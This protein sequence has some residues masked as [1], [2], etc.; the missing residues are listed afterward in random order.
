MQS[1]HP[2]ATTVL[3]DINF[4][5]V[6]EG[7]LAFAA[8]TFHN[9]LFSPMGSSTLSSSS[10]S[11]LGSSF[12]TYPTSRFECAFKLDL[13]RPH[14]LQTFR[15]DDPTGQHVGQIVLLHPAHLRLQVEQP[16]LQ[17]QILADQLLCLLFHIDLTLLAVLAAALRG[18]VVEVPGAAVAP[19]GPLLLSQVV[20]VRVLG[21]LTG[22]LG[23]PW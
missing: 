7:W 6:T 1:R 9:I 19:L 14:L 18:D 21:F 17:L 20:Q 4:T 12:P 23:R 15:I 22:S 11:L 3:K 5:L 13:R 2:A 16:L 8:L 10:L